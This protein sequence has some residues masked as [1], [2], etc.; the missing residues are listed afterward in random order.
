MSGAS[1]SLKAVVEREPLLVS[2]GK[3]L[4]MDLLSQISFFIRGDKLWRRLRILY[5]GSEA[6]FSMGSFETK[7]LKWQAPTIL[8]VSGTR[9]PRVPETHSQRTFC[10]TL[11]PRKYPPGGDVDGHVVYGVYLNVP[12]R[13]SH[14]GL[15][16]YPST[17]NLGL[18]IT[19]NKPRLLRRLPKHPLPARTHAPNLQSLNSINR[20]RLLQ[21]R[22]RRRLRLPYTEDE[23]PPTKPISQ[24]WPSILDFQ[25]LAGIRRVSACWKRGCVPYQ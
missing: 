23:V 14:R 20:L 18:S 6:G 8:L 19:N 13:I 16:N 10:D 21:Q 11:P 3:I 25:P 9:V 24:S 22:R 7:V 17:Q 2:S 4:N 1:S 5:A 15:I 12:W